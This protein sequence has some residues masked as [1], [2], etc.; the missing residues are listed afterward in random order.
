MK[1]RSQL[2]W[3]LLGLLLLG[4]WHQEIGSYFSQDDFFHLRQ[5]S[6]FGVAEIF[7][8]LLPKYSIEATF[9]RPISREI[10]SWVMF[11]LFGLNALAFHLVN[12]G[13]ILVN[14][15]LFFRFFVLLSK[16]RVIAMVGVGLYFLSAIHSVELYYLSSVQ[17][18]LSTFFGM[19]GL[20]FY[21]SNMQR[22][23]WQI[24]LLAMTI[25]GL[26][27]LSHESAAVFLGILVWL[28]LF[29][30]RDRKLNYQ[31]ILARISPLLLMVG[32]RGLLFLTATPL[33]SQVVYQPN[34]HPVSI[35]NTFIW[36]S[37]WC[38]G[39]PEMLV[40]FMTLTFKFNLNF[41]RFY[42]QFGAVVFPLVGLLAVAVAVGLMIVWKQLIDRRFWLI[43]LFYVTSL[44][45]FVF[46]PEHKYSY[47]LSLPVIWFNGLVAIVV[48][49]M[50]NFRAK[51]YRWFT[52]CLAVIVVV[53]LIIISLETMNLNKVTHWA[54]KRSAAALDIVSEVTR[55]LP[56]VPIGAVFYIRNDPNYPVIA[57]DWGNS[58][59]QAFFILSGS[60]AFQLIYRDPSIR[61]YY[62]DLGQVPETVDKSKL[63][64]YTLHFRY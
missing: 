21:L 16:K 42:G 26:G 49:E 9:Y 8:T 1:R 57:K 5:I 30:Y 45:P 7:R 61:V 20:N 53:C 10:Y 55:K 46:F 56:S 51:V 18:L 60:D 31:Q 17:T 3:I 38:L 29:F 63:I 54:A 48:V 23:R 41:W 52:R 12:F 50:W 40:D 36:L 32:G 59:K 27:L 64:E 39:L 37:L 19:S 62:E 33:P 15:Y 44:V 47:Y 35:A 25:F 4:V 2:L 43:G 28:E 58:S 13:L 22:R 14:G 34:F 24:Y 6:N 11:N